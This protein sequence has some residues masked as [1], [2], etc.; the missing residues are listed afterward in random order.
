M[1]FI[2][3]IIYYYY[4]Y[5]QFMNGKRWIMQAITLIDQ[6]AWDFALFAISRQADKAEPHL[7]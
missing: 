2:I 6:T 3:T 7:C 4:Y 1:L 5:A